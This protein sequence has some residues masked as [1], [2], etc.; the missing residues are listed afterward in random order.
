M[1]AQPVW[2]NWF[3]KDDLPESIILNS[4][5]PAAG[6]TETQV[7]KDMREITFSFAFDYHSYYFPQEIILFFEATYDEKKP[8]VNLVWSTPDGR[9][10]DLGNYSVTNSQA[11]Y[12]FLDEKLIN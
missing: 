1:Y 8:L 6:K 4:R 7:S 3:R 10:I 2:V 11:N 12:L 9:E 5:D